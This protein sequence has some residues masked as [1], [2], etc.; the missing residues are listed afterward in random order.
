MVS[1]YLMDGLGNWMFQIA[2]LEYL[3]L[4]SGRS[5]FIHKEGRRSPHSKEDYIAT[6]FEEWKDLHIGRE[7]HFVYEIDS[8]K[9][10]ALDIA[11]K[12]PE[13]C[14]VGW[15]Q[16]YKYISKSFLDKLRL[17]TE[18]LIRHPDIANTVFLHI[19]GGD[20]LLPQNSNHNVNLDAYYDKA[21][22]LFP[23]GTHF[24]IFTND[25]AYARTKPFL[26]LLSHT[27]I[28]E[29]ETHSMYLMSQCKGGICAN[30]SF[31]WWAAFLNPNRTLAIP[32]KW[33]NN[34]LSAFLN[35]GFQGST[36]VEV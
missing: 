19:R 8:I 33:V 7:E 20:F 12:Y 13:V 5:V 9:M 31:S 3:A 32:S 17:P 16:D 25:A 30:S 2:Y 4:Q 34:G 29:P 11:N 24:S 28:D 10:S 21:I 35:L 6:V 26:N 22:A 15:F 27:F 1:V 18:S 14:L 23:A 36:V